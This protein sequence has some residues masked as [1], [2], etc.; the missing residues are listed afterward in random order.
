MHCLGRPSR[1]H[2]RSGFT[3]IEIVVVLLI[4]SVVIAMATVIT[5]GVMAGQKRALTATRMA[6]V[7]TALMLYVQ[8][9]RRLPCPADGTVVTTAAGVGLEVRD[10]AGVCT[11]NQQNG[12]VP[13]RTLGITEN[14]ATDGWDH[15]ITYRVAPELAK[16]GAM[17]M[18]K[19]D[20]AGNDLTPVPGVCD[21]GCASTALSSCTSPSQF[22]GAIGLEV[23]SA[24]GVT[25]VADPTVGA[26]TGAA[27]LLISAGESGGGAYLSSGNLG[28]STSG[29]G[30]Q[31]LKNYA[32]LPYTP[33]VTYYIDNTIVDTQDLNHFDD[34]VVRPS[35]MSV[36]S[37]AGLGPR[38][39]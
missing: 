9:Q 3:L 21:P 24:D 36:V 33:L 26:N 14:D 31:E 5:R 4:L 23:R 17:D 16:D 35:I 34:V 20:P 11:G 32:S 39:H 18:S 37:K 38:A 29:D 27:Y 12:V 2:A 28:A 30:T 7:E 6:G 1:R 10:G 15:R 13:W 8:Q 25:K 22:L 19:C